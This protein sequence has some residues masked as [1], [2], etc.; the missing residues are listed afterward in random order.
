LGY[1]LRVAGE[2]RRPSLDVSALQLSADM[3]MEALPR[4]CANGA[5]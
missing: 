3:K 4:R 1:F 5:R 2:A